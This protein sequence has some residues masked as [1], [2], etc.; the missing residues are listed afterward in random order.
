MFDRPVRMLYR[1]TSEGGRSVVKLTAIASML[2]VSM[3]GRFNTEKQYLGAPL[4]GTTCLCSAQDYVSGG[5]WRDPARPA[6]G[7]VTEEAQVD[8][9]I[10]EPLAHRAKRK[11]RVGDR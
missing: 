6:S 7:A 9:R 8:R 5:F 1:R 4:H 10:N 3:Y 11:R 2:L